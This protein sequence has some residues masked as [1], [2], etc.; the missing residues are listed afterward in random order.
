M[1]ERNGGHQGRA[2]RVGIGSRGRGRGVE[3]GEEGGNRRGGGGGERRGAEGGGGGGEGGRIGGGCQRWASGRVGGIQWWGTRDIAGSHR[4]GIRW[5]SRKVIAELIGGLRGRASAEGGEEGRLKGWWVSGAEWWASRL[6]SPLRAR[7]AALGPRA[8]K[9]KIDIN[10][11]VGRA[12][13]PYIGPP[14]RLDCESPHSAS[15]TALHQLA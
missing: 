9:A 14:S 8:K 4:G 6:A 15:V 3:E 11:C 10:D 7:G 5:A 12:T 1:T 13:A 2:S